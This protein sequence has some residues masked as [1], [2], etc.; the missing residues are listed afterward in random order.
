MLS[1]YN[2]SPEGIRILRELAS[3][4]FGVGNVRKK[5]LGHLVT[6]S[7]EAVQDCQGNDKK[8]GATLK[9][10]LLL[11]MGQSEYQKDN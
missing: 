7:K 3:S 1:K 6:E 10:L 11:R 8:I 5:N 4:W 2:F 9:R